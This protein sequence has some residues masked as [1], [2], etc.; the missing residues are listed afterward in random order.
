MNESP[1]H[2]AYLSDIFDEEWAFVAPSLALMNESAS[3]RTV[4]AR[5]L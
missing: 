1:C 3:Q 5:S 2:K 4:D